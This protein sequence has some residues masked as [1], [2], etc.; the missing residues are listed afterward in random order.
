MK[1]I[2]SSENSDWTATYYNYIRIQLP[3]YLKKTLEISPVQTRSVTRCTKT[4]GTSAMP[5]FQHDDVTMIS[6]E[7]NMVPAC[8]SRRSVWWRH[9]WDRRMPS[10]SHC[11]ED[12]CF[13]FLM[14]PGYGESGDINSRPSAG[15]TWEF[16]IS[17]FWIWIFRSSFWGSNFKDC[18]LCSGCSMTWATQSGWTT[19]PWVFWT[20]PQRFLEHGETYKHGETILYTVIVIYMYI[21]SIYLWN[22]TFA[23]KLWFLWL[24]IPS[25]LKPRRDRFC[26]AWRKRSQAC[27]ITFGSKDTWT[28]PEVWRVRWARKRG[29]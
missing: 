13:F 11:L 2:Y 22:Q 25:C 5:W 18:S 28:I 9:L 12:L 23:L 27:G 14:A 1:W 8:S 4:W 29:T 17:Q 21:Y 7:K 26:Y 6:P 15:L 24:L 10:A 19:L 16:V 20:N 3:T